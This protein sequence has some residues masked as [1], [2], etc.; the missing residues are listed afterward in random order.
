MKL[1]VGLG[2]PGIA[3]KKT[4]HNVGFM[5]ID[6]FCQKAKIKFDQKK[7]GGLF[8]QT[9]INNQKIMLLKPQKYMNLSGEI[10]KQFID[11]YNIPIDEILVIHDDMDIELGKIKLK[12]SGS[13]G[14]HNGL[15]NIEEN[16]KTANY[17]R[18]KVGIS[19]S[20]NYDS[21]DYV[22]GKFTKEEATKITEIME[23]VVCA[24]NDY[25]N[26]DFVNLMNKYNKK[27]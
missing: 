24:I 25:I 1:I 22:L 11:Y 10:I 5:A 14:G 12:L 13:S 7:F 17:K 19:K 20:L 4:R 8:T 23:V 21:K 27:K 16:I 6:L 9:I 18:L 26:M 15:K 3:F 2:N